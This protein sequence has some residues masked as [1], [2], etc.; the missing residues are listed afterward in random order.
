[1][2]IDVGMCSY[3]DNRASIAQIMFSSCVL[4]ALVSSEVNYIIH[5]KQ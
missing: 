3:V 4:C 2:S 1:M 5:V